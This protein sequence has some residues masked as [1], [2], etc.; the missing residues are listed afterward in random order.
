MGM[1]LRCK[2]FPRF[3][4]LRRVGGV[5]NDSSFSGSRGRYGLQ[6]SCPCL[7]PEFTENPSAG[8]EA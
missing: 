2:V 3:Q 8:V 6:C 1:T 4:N 7:V 5:L